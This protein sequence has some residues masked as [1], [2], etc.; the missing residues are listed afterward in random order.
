[1]LAADGSGRNGIFTKNLLDNIDR[2]GLTL[3]QVFKRTG[4]GVMRETGGGQVP[5]TTSSVFDDVYFSGK[6]MVADGSTY[7]APPS[8]PATQGSLRI[9]SQPSG[10]MVFV[11]GNRVGRTPKTLNGLPAGRVRIEA[12]LD[13]YAPQEKIATVLGGQSVHVG[14]ALTRPQAEAKPGRLYVLP[15]PGDATVRILNIGP[16]YNRGMSLKPGR[17]HVEVSKSGYGT[18]RQWVE[19]RAG[20]DLDVPVTL[21]KKAVA[22]APAPRPAA[23]A[24]PS[25][26]KTWRDPTTGMEFV[27]VPGGCYQMGSNSRYDEKPVHK[28]CVDGFWMGKYEV[29]QAEWMGVMGNNPSAYPRFEMVNPVERVSWF[30][31]QSFIDVLNSKGRVY[32]VCRRKLNG[33]ML[34]VQVARK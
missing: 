21:E 32:F 15:K 30:D 7:G 13:G 31:S 23:P 11:D 29:T 9:E 26:G 24:S 34:P 10:A 8:Q 33:S 18:V 17:Y 3:E 20:Q 2:K 5:W 14:L 12:R 6:T 19:L 16:R 4:R 27:W 25:P 28:V 1:M 22:A